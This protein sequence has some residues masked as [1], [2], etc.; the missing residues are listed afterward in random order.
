MNKEFQRMQK[1]A[2]LITEDNYPYEL[3]KP[4]PNSIYPAGDAWHK[5]STGKLIDIGEDPSHS[6]YPK[7]TPEEHKEIIDLI[8]GYIKQ[9][10]EN[11]ENTEYYNNGVID[12]I[13]QVVKQHQKKLR[14][15]E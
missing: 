7:L 13:T 3:G 1:L 11:F 10:K 4:H 14:D 5:L 2:G 8:M 12:S 6:R 15:I 9:Y